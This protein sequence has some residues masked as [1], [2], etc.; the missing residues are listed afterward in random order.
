M[1][2]SFN[3]IR[4]ASRENEVYL[5][6]FNQKAWLSDER[7]ML[8]A[9]E[10]LEDY[11]K[12]VKVLPIPT[13]ASKYLWHALVFRSFFSPRSYNVNWITSKEMQRM[14][15]SA[16]RKYQPDIIH[17]DTI[18]LDQYV[19]AE[20][21]T[22]MVLNH[23]NIESHMMLRRAEKERNPLKKV[24]FLIEGAKL[25]SYEKKICPLVGMNVVVSDL[26]K[27]RLLQ[28]TPQAMV[29]V[30][31]NG[32]DVSYF[33]PLKIKISPHSL[34]FAG[35]MDWYPNQDAMVYFLNH[36]WARIKVADQYSTLTIAG[37]K[38]S[39]K[40]KKM[41][42]PDPS[43]KLTGFIED[44]RPLIDQAEVY[45]CPIRDGG[46]TKLKLL[47]AMGMEKAIVTTSLGAEGLKVKNGEHVL[48]A[49]DSETFVQKICM[50]FDNEELRHSL[51]KNGRRFVEKYYAWE[52]IGRELLETYQVVKQ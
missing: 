52:V 11:C 43:I 35:S 14:V 37:R 33:K 48:I 27:G 49:D 47:D 40:L 22:K 41:T 31:R 34:I 28:L 26:D 32:V 24:Y 51:A 25:R 16:I 36:I 18:G 5:C 7:Q 9:K 4:E 13:D 3:L 38:P 46:G 6:T 19:A 45:V 2:R 50:L 8:A 29:K 20:Y 17:C 44:I 12:V 15:D 1:Q 39:Q 21:K 23:H 42:S 30:V 10:K